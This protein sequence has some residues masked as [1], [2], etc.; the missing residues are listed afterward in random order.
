MLKGSA[1]IKSVLKMK[2]FRLFPKK[3]AKVLKINI[4][5]NE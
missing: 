3:I 2:N 4:E 5:K 1:C